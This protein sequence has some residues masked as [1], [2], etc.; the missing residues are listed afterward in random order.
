MLWQHSEATTGGVEWFD[1]QLESRHKGY[2]SAMGLLWV[3]CKTYF[4][5]SSPFHHA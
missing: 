5:V 2:Q 1:R 4:I 3:N